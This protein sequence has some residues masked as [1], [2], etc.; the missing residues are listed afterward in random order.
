MKVSVIVPGYN[1]EACVKRCLDSLINQTL[2]D[3]EIIFIDDGSTDKT[4]SIVDEY[5]LN[6]NN[7]KVLHVKNGGQSKA[8]NLGMKEA[9]GDFLAFLD[10]DDYVETTMYEKLYEKAISDD[11][12][13][14]VC[15]VNI[16][17]PKKNVT[18][19][20][21]SKT[22]INNLEDLKK[23]LIFSYSAGVV[24][25]KLYKKQILEDI[26]FKENV[27]YEDVHFNFKLFPSLN[28]IGV[29]TEPLINYVQTEGSITYTYN[30]KLYDIINNFNDLINYYKEHGLYQKF[31]SELEY[32]YI[33]YTYNTFIKRL[34]KCGSFSKFMEGVSF[35]KKEVKTNFPKYRKNKFITSP[36]NIK[37]IFNNVY[38]IFFN[39]FFAAFIYLINIGKMN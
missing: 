30:E 4:P 28:K 38:Y 33:R 22:D 21:G 32:S 31:Y 9:T 37:A 36:R 15:D 2:K 26:D 19:S 1:A 11:F 7:I 29:V 17:Y 24:W 39:N 16:I 6:Y 23:Y 5:A 20:N 10:S 12:D 35:V 18:I 3:L 13:I 14:T 34:A 8:R 25:N 27:W